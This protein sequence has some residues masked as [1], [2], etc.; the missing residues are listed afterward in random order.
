MHWLFSNV[1][2]PFPH[3]HLLVL[4][5]LHRGMCTFFVISGNAQSMCYFWLASTHHGSLRL[6]NNGGILPWPCGVRSRRGMWNTIL[7]WWAEFL[8]EWRNRETTTFESLPFSCVV[9]WI[10]FF[11]GA[12]AVQNWKSQIVLEKPAKNW[13]ISWGINPRVPQ[14]PVWRREIEQ[15]HVSSNM[16]QTYVYG[17]NNFIYNI[18]QDSGFQKKHLKTRLGAMDAISWV[19]IFA[20]RFIIMHLRRRWRPELGV[21]G[22]LVSCQLIRRTPSTMAMQHFIF[23]AMT[24]ELCLFLFLN[25]FVPELHHFLTCDWQE[26]WLKWHN[27]IICGTTT[28]AN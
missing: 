28:K 25:H 4:K 14:Q 21:A 2:P 19:G 23:F 1:F 10:F 5:T 7:A 24:S 15:H 26:H 8:W 11:G 3:K 13:K 12:D 20:C 22:M 6:R 16:Y 9:A 18:L 17:H 27:K